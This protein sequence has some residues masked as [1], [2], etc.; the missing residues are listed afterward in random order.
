VALEA[1]AIDAVAGSWDGGWILGDPFAYLYD[2]STPCSTSFGCT[3]P[4]CKPFEDGGN[5]FAQCVVDCTGRRP[6]QLAPAPRASGTPLAAYFASMAHLEAA[7]VHAFR[8]LR[9]QLVA[10]G[11]P[12]RLVRA[13][14]R[15]ARDE[16]RH[17]RMTTALARR[18]GSVPLP[19]AVGP[20]EIGTLEAMALENAVEGCTREAFGALVATWQAQAAEDPHVRAALTRIARDETRHAALAFQVRAWLDTRLDGA[21]RARVRRA[22]R[23]ALEELSSREVEAPEA[24]RRRLGLPSASQARVLAQELGRLAA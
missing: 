2:A 8:H 5:W 16:I 20:M 9:R 23:A 7:S 6:A 14:E 17:A 3:F 11:A 4:S 21:A 15:A 18:H 22:T 12:R 19:V 1:G 13:A 24:L 10:H